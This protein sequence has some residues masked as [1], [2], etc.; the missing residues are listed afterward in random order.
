MVTIDRTVSAQQGA[1]CKTLN[2]GVSALVIGVG[3]YLGF[4]TAGAQAAQSENP[5]Y[6]LVVAVVSLPAHCWDSAG[7]PEPFAVV[8]RTDPEI[9]TQIAAVT[10]EI[11]AN[12]RATERIEDRLRAAE[13]EGADS[14]P[15]GAMERLRASLERL[16]A[17]EEALTSERLDL[18]RQVQL[19]LVPPAVPRGTAGLS[20]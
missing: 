2:T 12:N 1:G 6:G 16:Q 3:L 9:N 17:T 4:W 18:R 13:R 7:A 11:V 14:L 10:R 20:R 19:D 15:A 5:S 8:E